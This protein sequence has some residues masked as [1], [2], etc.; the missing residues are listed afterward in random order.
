MYKLTEKEN[1][2]RMFDGEIPEYLPKYDFFGW[3]AGLPFV[4]DKKSA[5]GYVVDEFGVELATTEVS[6]GGMMPA[7]GRIFLKDIRKWRDVVKAPD[8]SDWDWEKLTKEALKDKDI[9]NKPV[10]LHNGGYFMTLMNFMGFAEGL[11]AMEEEPEEVY[12]LFEYLSDYYIA[13]EKGL[14]Q[15]FHGDIYELADDTAAHYFPFISPETYQK[16]VK[17]FAKREADLA[18]DAGLKIAMHDC[19]KSDVFI[20]DWIDMGVQL[21]EPAQTTN[22]LRGV[23][24]KYG[25]KLILTGAW[26]NQGPISYPETPD[27]ELKEALKVYV[28]TFAPDGGFCYMPVVVGNFTDEP[29][30]RKMKLINDFYFEYARDWYKNNGY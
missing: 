7:P 9:E 19:G 10:I 13:R 26:D 2:L 5:D 18:R 11:C 28:D 20:D 16:L 15:Y 17:P 3:G 23:K 22:D 25:R 8:V 21:W 27:E 29:F 12:E 4:T 24:K 30:Q 14:L 1:L 6:M